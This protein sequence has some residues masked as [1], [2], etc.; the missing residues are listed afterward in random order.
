MKDFSIKPYKLFNKIQNYAW[1]T[2]NEK[3]FIPNLLGIKVIQD[4][5]YAELW[6]GAHPSASSE[7]LIDGRKIPLNKI[8]EEYPEAFLGNYVISRFGKQLP[9]LL[10]VLSAS[11]ALSIQTHPDKEQARKLHLY[12]PE[13]YPDENHKPEIAIAIDSLTAFAGFRP[14]KEI[15][16]NLKNN[17]EIL[18]FANTELI[19]LNSDLL[20]QEKLK[21]RLK[22]IYQMLMKKSSDKEMLEKIIGR[23]TE[24]LSDKEKLSQEEF[25]FLKQHKL[26]GAD[27][28]LLSF[29]F[30]NMVELKPGQAIFTGA[31]VPHAYIEGNIV[32]CMANSDNV[33]RAGLTN[34]FKDV[35]TLLEILHFDFSEYKI[36]NKKQETDNVVYKTNASEFEVT[37]FSKKS[38]FNQI[39]NSAG[40]PAVILIMDGS[41]EI[42][43]EIS[44]KRNSEI[45][46]KGES[47]LIPAVLSKF[48]L[49]CAENA[50]FFLVRV[51]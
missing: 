11:D 46:L 13:K 40:R 12:D 29:F 47:F 24:R 3:A 27:A 20:S 2:R 25:Q 42:N 5:P 4:L 38:G 21:E 37:A 15:V 36:I 50:V 45:F 33:V 14:V 34:K 16:Q 18:E 23:I 51:P 41:V 49:T 28:G 32:E 7:I 22:D 17:S 8:I 1:G 48:R 43:L 44:G 39:F 9:F 31:G 35:D 10:K 26:F 19:K 30:F 6:I